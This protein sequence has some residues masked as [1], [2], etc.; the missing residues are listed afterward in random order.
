MV[1]ESSR[2]ESQSTVCYVEHCPGRSRL[3]KSTFWHKTRCRGKAYAD[4]RLAF[5]FRT[6]RHCPPQF[7]YQ[8]FHSQTHCISGNI[9]TL[10]NLG[11]GH[12][13]RVVRVFAGVA[14]GRYSNRRK[15][16][17]SEGW[18]ASLPAGLPSRSH[19]AESGKVSML[20]FRP[21]AQDPIMAISQGRSLG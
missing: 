13:K 19:P 14:W 4:T 21:A 18:T 10:A 2:Q 20:A 5:L 15:Y 16:R 3:W 7:D 6:P 12:D 1:L 8:F 9:L 17:G 11:Q